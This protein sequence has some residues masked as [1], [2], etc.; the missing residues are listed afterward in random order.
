MYVCVTCAVITFTITYYIRIQLM[1]ILLRGRLYPL[2]THVRNGQIK[3]TFLVIEKAAFPT[4]VSSKDI[5]AVLFSSFF[6][7]N[8]HYPPGCSTSLLCWKYSL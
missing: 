4:T 8:E 1:F 6:V 3:D 5:I 2:S 7:F